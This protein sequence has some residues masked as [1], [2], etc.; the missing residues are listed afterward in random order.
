[1][2]KRH[3][4]YVMKERVEKRRVGKDEKERDE[5]KKEHQG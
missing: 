3:G 5:C 1:L 2:K 4:L